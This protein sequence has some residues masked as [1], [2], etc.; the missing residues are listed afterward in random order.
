MNRYSAGRR[1]FGLVVSPTGFTAGCEPWATSHN[2]GIVPPL[3][4]RRLAF[5]E[6]TVLRRFER[7]LTALRARV[8]LRFDD[9]TTEPAFFDFVYR[10]VADFEGHQEAE[11]GS[12]YL[13]YPKRW[14][15]SFGE[16]YHF[17]AGRLIED[18]WVGPNGSVAKL[19]GNAMLQFRSHVLFGHSQILDAPP[20]PS[21]QC[22]KN[23]GFEPCAL[24]FVKS[25]V[26]G[27]PIT[28]AGDFGHYIEIF[29]DDSFNLGFH[30]TYF[31][32]IWA[33]TPVEDHRL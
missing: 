2:L 27:K 20:R 3:K 28:S 23:I 4:G 7:T 17:I 26:V 24:D 8:R 31:H 29:L 14:A 11:L 19:S 10:L 6:D 1:Y 21:P 33:E 25:I 32:I 15:S 12:R 9:L 30:D 22:Y 18:L 5:N 13:L 16:M